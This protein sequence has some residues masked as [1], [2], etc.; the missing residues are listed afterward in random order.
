MQKDFVKARYDLPKVSN[1]IAS[2]SIVVKEIEEMKERLHDI[3]ESLMS[4]Q[5]SVSKLIQLGKDTSTDIRMVHCVLDNLKK[6]VKI[7]NKVFKQV[8]SIKIE[9]KYSH[10]ELAISMQKSY[11]NFSKNVERSYERFC[12]KYII[13]FPISSKNT[14]LPLDNFISF[15]GGLFFYFGWSI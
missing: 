1:F 14:K 5:E 10:N 11:S 9:V 7:F 13:S 8:D 2:T 3:E 15:K 6:G 4:L 12:H